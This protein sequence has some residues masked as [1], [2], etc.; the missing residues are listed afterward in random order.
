MRARRRTQRHTSMQAQC[1]G[2]LPT[3]RAA[4]KTRQGVPGRDGPQPALPASA[5]LRGSPSPRVEG[6]ALELVS[7]GRACAAGVWH[8]RRDGKTGL[9]H[10]RLVKRREPNATRRCAARSHLRIICWGEVGSHDCLQ[11]RHRL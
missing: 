7:H 3:C 4:E 2:V 9:R 1:Q 11:A 5:G 8:V 6:A 10:F